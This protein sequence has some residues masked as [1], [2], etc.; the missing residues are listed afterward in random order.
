MMGKEEGY[1]GFEE[2]SLA[3]VAESHGLGCT[4]RPRL[5]RC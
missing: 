1:L 2:G 5:P 3:E 4:P